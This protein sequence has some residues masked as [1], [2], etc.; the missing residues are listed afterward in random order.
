MINLILLFPDGDIWGGLQTCN[1]SFYPLDV[2]LGQKK[3]SQKRRFMFTADT[4]QQSQL[5]TMAHIF[6]T[7]TYE[8]YKYKS[9]VFTTFILH[10][11][12]MVLLNS[13]E[14]FCVLALCATWMFELSVFFTLLQ[15]IIFCWM[16]WQ[17]TVLIHVFLVFCISVIFHYFIHISQS[18]TSD[19]VFFCLCL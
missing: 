3:I 6:Q 7:A 14:F 12:F 10:I 18:Y 11:Y 8:R 1:L 2:S 15:I 5:S 4:Q 13:F 19:F 9:F 17:Q 16:Y